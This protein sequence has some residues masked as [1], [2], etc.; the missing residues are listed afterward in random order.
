MLDV[1]AAA[2]DSSSAVSTHHSEG[3]TLT[4]GLSPDTNIAEDPLCAEV[5]PYVRRMLFY[6]YHESVANIFKIS[7]TIV[8]AH[9]TRAVHKVQ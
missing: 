6:F 8:E 3:C 1:P 7:F 9:I 2:Q 4:P 5:S